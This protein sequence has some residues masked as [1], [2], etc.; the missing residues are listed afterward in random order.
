MVRNLP[1]IQETQVQSPGG[2]DPLE[3]GMLPSVLPGE[4]QRQRSL[5]G[6]TVHGVAKSRIC[7]TLSLFEFYI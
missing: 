1:A 4:F 5:V 2:E 3:K 7:L 6:Y